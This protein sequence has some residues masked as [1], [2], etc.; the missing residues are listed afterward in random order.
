MYCYSPSVTVQNSLSEIDIIFLVFFYLP[1]S[2][3]QKILS[4]MLQPLTKEPLKKPV[5]C[6]YCGECVWFH[7]AP[8]QTVSF[9]NKRQVLKPKTS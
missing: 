8:S 6:V 2:A 4:Q 5:S 3:N 7:A 9:E 1:I